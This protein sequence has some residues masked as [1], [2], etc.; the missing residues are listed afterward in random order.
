MMIGS[1]LLDNAEI[2]W[3]SDK[4]VPSSVE[5][6]G[7]VHD[8]D[9]ETDD[10]TNPETRFH[11]EVSTGNGRGCGQRHEHGG[12]HGRGHRAHGAARGTLTI[13]HLSVGGIC[14]S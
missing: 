5:E 4:E 3:G 2:F 13:V 9:S 12:G 7:S 11:Q 1:E 8:R 14:M 10:D 6:D